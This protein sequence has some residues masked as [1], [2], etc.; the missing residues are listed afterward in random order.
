MVG[1]GPLPRGEASSEVWACIRRHRL[2]NPEDRR[3]IL[4]DDRLEVVF[5]AKR[6]TMLEMNKHLARHLV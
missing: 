4:A 6:V 5:G 2:R 3:A 1:A